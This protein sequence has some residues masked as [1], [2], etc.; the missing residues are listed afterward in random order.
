MLA[1]DFRTV[2]EGHPGKREG[3]GSQPWP[4]LACEG[5]VT[6]CRFPR[7][8]AIFTSLLSML[9]LTMLVAHASVHAWQLLCAHVLSAS[10]FASRQLRRAWCLM[11]ACC[12]WLCVRRECRIFRHPEEHDSCDRR[13]L[14]SP[15]SSSSSSSPPPHAHTSCS[16]SCFCLTLLAQFRC[17]NCGE[18][19]ARLSTLSTTQEKVEVP[20]S[21]GVA[22]LVQKCKG[23]GRTNS[24][25]IVPG[26][27]APYGEYVPPPC[28]PPPSSLCLLS[29]LLVSAFTVPWCMCKQ[30]ACATWRGVVQSSYSRPACA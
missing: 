3:V 1:A 19:S 9:M 26:S 13:H 30:P 27:E 23:C 10:G 17:A 5:R 29:Q 12:V 6:A 15:V 18:D 8:Q 7:A 22:D 21:R 11:H 28:P 2:R 24:V 16:S 14:Q 20:G 25:D 4:E